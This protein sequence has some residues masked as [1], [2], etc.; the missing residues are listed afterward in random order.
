MSSY[1][2]TIVEGGSPLHLA[3]L[4]TLQA[5]RWAVP[6]SYSSWPLHC[7]VGSWLWCRVLGADRM[8][9]TGFAIH[10]TSSRALPGT[11]IGQVDRL[12]RTL[13]EEIAS[14]IGDV[15]REAARQIPR[16]LR[17]DVRI[18]DENAARRRAMSASFEAAGWSPA[19]RRRQYSHTLLLDLAS[20]EHETLRCFSK[21]V[22]TAVRK[23]LGSPLLR[24]APVVG[25]QYHE[26]IEFLYNLTFK[27][28]GGVP[29]PIDING[30][31]RDSLGGNNSLLIGAFAR[32]QRAPDDLVALAWGR[33]HGDYADL[34]VNAS[35]RSPLFTNSLSPGFGLMWRLF[36]WAIEH[37]AHW[38]DLGGLSD[39][40]PAP[41]DPLR[42]IVEFKMRFSRDFR[43]VAEEWQLEPHPMLSGAADAA[44][45]VVR[46]VQRVHDGMGDRIASKSASMLLFEPRGRAASQRELRVRRRCHECRVLRMREVMERIHPVV[47]FLHTGT[48]GAHTLYPADLAL[49]M[50]VIEL[51]DGE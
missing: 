44:R 3:D 32:D 27:R 51:L 19:V 18:F 28:T 11:R 34:A 41:E 22:R 9:L 12:G 43:E 48:M 25:E 35:E 36:A 45:R 13:H 30:I 29:P 42:G 38:M 47:P 31:L 14:T 37:G 46:L 40:N 50:R 39:T 49:R 7:T 10:L 26:R 1:A 16:L 23:A 24:Y 8:L 4:R 6:H 17:L 5:R 21:G 20:S 33:L 15:L 2:V